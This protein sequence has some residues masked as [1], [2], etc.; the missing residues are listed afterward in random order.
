MGRHERIGTDLFSFEK[1]NVALDKNVRKF[2]DTHPDA[3][4][5]VFSSYE[6]LARVFADPPKFGFAAEGVHQEGGPAFY[7]HLHPTTAIHG[8]VA[9]DIHEFLVAQAPHSSETV[10]T[11]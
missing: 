11:A 9:H 8:I 10:A 1:W 7:D 2:V 5:F 4:V 6:C 3:T